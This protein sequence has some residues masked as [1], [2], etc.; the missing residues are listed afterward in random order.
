MYQDGYP[1]HCRRN[2]GYT[3]NINGYDVDNRDVVP[4]NAYLSK[5]FNCHINVAVCA[6]EM[7]EIYPQVYLQRT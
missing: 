7:R 6:H 2:D 3:Y 5:M 4:Y 1:I